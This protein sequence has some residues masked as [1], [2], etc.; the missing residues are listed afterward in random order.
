[1]THH[2]NKNQPIGGEKEMIEL[3][4]KDIK[5]AIINILHVFRRVEENM[6]MPRRERGVIF[7]KRDPNRTSRNENII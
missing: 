1:M 6:S 2:Q 3:A 5:A 7:K 4:D